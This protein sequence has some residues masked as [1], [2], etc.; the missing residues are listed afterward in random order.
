MSLNNAVPGSVDWNMT[1]RVCKIWLTWVNKRN[2]KANQ[3]PMCDSM[4]IEEMI[5]T[6]HYR[7]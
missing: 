1:E 6:I 5:C 2:I 4:V 7:T 3:S